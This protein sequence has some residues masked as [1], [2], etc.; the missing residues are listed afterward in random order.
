MKAVHLIEN[1]EIRYFLASLPGRLETIKKVELQD[2]STQMDVIAPYF[3][4]HASLPQIVAIMTTRPGSAEAGEPFLSYPLK[5][6]R[7]HSALLKNTQFL[8]IAIQVSIV[9]LNVVDSYNSLLP[10][11]NKIIGLLGKELDD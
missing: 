6:T 4:T 10:D 9:Q 5:E 1:E 11:L 8:G 3:R 2:Y 7:D